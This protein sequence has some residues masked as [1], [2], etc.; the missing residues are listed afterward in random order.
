MSDP[1]RYLIDPNIV[2]HRGSIAEDDLKV[3]LVTDA[4][5]QAGWTGAD[6]K[7]L[8]GVSWSIRR[9]AGRRGGYEIEIRRDIRLSNQ[10]RLPKPDAAD[11]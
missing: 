2:M 4:L 10:S 9:G 5:E 7:P 1:R 11:G 8:N 3:R 6:G